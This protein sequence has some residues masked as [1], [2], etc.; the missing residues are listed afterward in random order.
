[1]WFPFTDE[2]YNALNASQQTYVSG[3]GA[4]VVMDNSVLQ[5]A[6]TA[7]W[8]L[9]PT[10]TRGGTPLTIANPFNPGLDLAPAQGAVL[11]NIVMTVATTGNDVQNVIQVITGVPVN[12]N[13][14]AP[15][16][17]FYSDIDE[18]MLGG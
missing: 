12:E 1:M 17:H 14:Q 9:S 3:A 4:G 15:A 8:E 6:T 10:N 7:P 2:A 11:A 13:N 5:P 16:I 18:A